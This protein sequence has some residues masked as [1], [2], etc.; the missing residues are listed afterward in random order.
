[1]YFSSCKKVTCLDLSQTKNQSF[2]ICR[3]RFHF[4]FCW[5]LLTT[6]NT[7]Y[8]IYVVVMAQHRSKDCIGLCYVII[9]KCEPFWPK[10]CKSLQKLQIIILLR[11]HRWYFSIFSIFLCFFH[12]YPSFFSLSSNYSI[13]KMLTYEAITFFS[14]LLYVIYI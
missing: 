14:I 10:Y 3:G 2:S 7:F 5:M 11:S 4:M 9:S 8:L 12:P 6:K 13:N 1:M